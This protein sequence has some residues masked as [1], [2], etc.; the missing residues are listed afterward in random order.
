MAVVNGY[1]TLNAVKQ[2]LGANDTEDDDNIDAAIN[3]ASRGID[4]H[5]GRRFWQDSEDRTVYFNPRGSRILWFGTDPDNADLDTLASLSE[6]TDGINFTPLT[7][8]VDFYLSPRSGPASKAVRSG[9]WPS[10]PDAVEVVG[11]FGIDGPPDDVVL[12]ATMW[13]SRL[14][15]RSTEAP[16]G[17]GMVNMQDDRTF[18][19]PSRFIDGD[20]EL[21]L[22]PHRLMQVTV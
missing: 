6:S 19:R 16:M 9:C 22:R 21:L 17:A 1:T 12:A 5:C 11:R 4:E 2:T 3:A 20:I 10:L 7:V 15:K 14:F 18:I 8:D 13:A